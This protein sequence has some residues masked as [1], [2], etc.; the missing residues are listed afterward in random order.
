MK[1][2]LKEELWRAFNNR[3]YWVVFALAIITFMVS[4]YRV[5]Y[6]PDLQ[7]IHPVNLLTIMLSSPSLAPLATLMAVLPYADSM[8]DDRNSGFLRGINLRTPY[9]RY[10]T[11]KSIA[12]GLSGGVGVCAWLLLTF[13]LTLVTTNSD[14]ANLSFVSLSTLAPE[15]PWGPLGWLYLLNP[16]Y[17]LAFLLITSFVFGVVY[18]LIGL[19]I[20]SVANNRYVVL[21]APLVFYQ[22]FTFLESRMTHMPP[23]W[24][25]SY[26]LLPF[27]AYEGF[28]LVQMSI[29]FTVLLVGSIG[30]LLVFGRRSN[31]VR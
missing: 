16:L 24:N 25:P 17:Y 3:R 28:S 10:L 30:C 20:S 14:L 12:V 29:Q 18:A 31:T 26:T 15:T 2:I 13:L 21:A 4:W 8:I 1:G 27:E 6:L 11:S 22:L 7:Y 5:R 9:R 23:M 19:A